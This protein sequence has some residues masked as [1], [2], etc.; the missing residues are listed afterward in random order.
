MIAHAPGAEV[1]PA[2]PGERVIG[3]MVGTVRRWSEEFIPVNM[4]GDAGRLLGSCRDA[5]GLGP[6]R[7]VRPDM[8]L[9][10]G[11]NYPVLD[12]LDRSAQAVFRRSLVA[13]LGGDL[14]LCRRIPHQ[15]GFVDRVRQRLLAV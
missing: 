12:N 11:P 4:S 7:P 10:H 2:P 8:C 15:S 13:H 9:A 3:R 1:P 14:V 6:D 5:G